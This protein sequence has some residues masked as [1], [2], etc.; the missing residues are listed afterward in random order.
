MK[1]SF[2]GLLLALLCI[3]TAA[4]G[5]PEEKGRP[6]PDLPP[7]GASISLAPEEK[8]AGAQNAPEEKPAPQASGTPEEEPLPVSQE[9]E[10]WTLTVDKVTADRSF[11]T[12]VVTMTA[13]EGTALDADNY[14]LDCM[15]LVGDAGGGF[16]VD[17]LP[18]DDPADN[19]L[20]FSVDMTL[21]SGAPEE[22]I[23]YVTGLKGVYFTEG[24]VGEAFFPVVT[25]SWSVPF[26]LE[27]AG[28][29]L[30]Y[31]LDKEVST[32]LGRLV[33]GR[34]E[35][36]PRS[37]LITLSGDTAA[38]EGVEAAYPG[39]TVR[40]D[41]ILLKL[42]DQSGE[43]VLPGM[44]AYSRGEGGGWELTLSFDSPIDPKALGSIVL[45]GVEI[46]LA[47]KVFSAS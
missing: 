46:Q 10:G 25:G 28:E 36:G 31:R 2:F 26:R 41:R 40:S 15:P 7:E 47:E 6:A 4:C 34:V 42:L 12:L 13:P 32:H 45:D 27:P 20:S 19:R 35:V 21:G 11:A 23:L 3:G 14:T 22:G 16:S 18:D 43:R 17:L 39:A 5:K 8:P 38:V 30:T 44:S 24:H 29:V 1:R 33:I 37:A 9:A